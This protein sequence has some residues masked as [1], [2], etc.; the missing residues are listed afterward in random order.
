VNLTLLFVL[1]SLVFVLVQGAFLGLIVS[2]LVR[3]YIGNEKSGATALE[4]GTMDLLPLLLS[5]VFIIVVL[6]AYI[7]LSAL[8]NIW[9]TGGL[10]VI[11]GYCTY[12][13]G[14]RML[15]ILKKIK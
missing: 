7:I 5:A 3:K 1:A 4:V 8:M 13:L 2:R 6:S 9:V 15:A 10:L 12:W 14:K 11:L